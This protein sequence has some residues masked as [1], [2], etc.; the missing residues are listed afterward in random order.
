MLDSLA[1]PPRSAT[2]SC[3]RCCQSNVMPPLPLPEGAQTSWQTPCWCW[4]SVLW[5]L[6][7]NG[8]RGRTE[9]AGLWA[10]GTIGVY[11]SIVHRVAVSGLSC[12]KEL[13]I[14]PTCTP[15]SWPIRRG[16]LTC[17]TC[18]MMTGYG[19]EV[20]DTRGGSAGH[21]G[22][23]SR[24]WAR[25]A[26]LQLAACICI[27]GTSGSHACLCG[28]NVSSRIRVLT[29]MS[30]TRF[31]DRDVWMHAFPFNAQPEFMEPS[32]FMD[33][34]GVTHALQDQLGLNRT[35]TM[36][37]RDV[38]GNSSLRPGRSTTVPYEGL[39]VHRGTYCLCTC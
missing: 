38:P 39:L 17:S 25:H 16:D 26:F 12:G 37:Q 33:A 28:V 18:V 13:P 1:L 20:P 15:I 35:I 23:R 32:L 6:P 24:V 31:C 9:A 8:S 21:Q 3:S 14:A 19:T 36:S 5:R 34:V 2:V 4:C 10:G 30:L 29:T 27:D 7:A 22:V 11:A